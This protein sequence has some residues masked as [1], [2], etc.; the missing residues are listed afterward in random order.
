MH[1]RDSSLILP[2]RYL[3]Q[4]APFG[5]SLFVFDVQPAGRTK[6]IQSYNF[7][8]SLSHERVKFTPFSPVGLAFYAKP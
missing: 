4:L 6:M 5:S 7:T 1:P 8:R 2:P 3:Y